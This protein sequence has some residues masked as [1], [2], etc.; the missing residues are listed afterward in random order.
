MLFEYLIVGLLGL[1]VGSFLNALIWR[2]HEGTSVLVGRSKCTSCSNTLAWKD[3]VPLISYLLLG[4]RCRTCTASISLQYPLVEVTTA[5]LFLFA[6][7]V[8]R[9]NAPEG[10]LGAFFGVS[11]MRDA[12]AFI[13][14][15]F[16]LSVLVVIFVY[17]FRWYL[18][19]DIVTIPTIVIGFL[20]SGFLL[21]PSPCVGVGVHCLLSNPWINLLFA[22]LIAGGFFLAQYGISGGR[23]IGGGD[24]RLGF[25]MGVMVG[26]PGVLAALF[27]AYMFGSIIGLTL[28]AIGKR[29]AEAKFLLVLS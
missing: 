12:L 8:Y 22:A 7:G 3:L 16:F 29:N 5:L 13:L 26:F 6:Y 10:L 11:A 2:L 9:L 24:I 23:W 21:S 1:V 15:L 4:G 14:N 19:P 27:F 28:I 20:L 18:I 25:L 17:D